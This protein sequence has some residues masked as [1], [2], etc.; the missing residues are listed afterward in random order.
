MELFLFQL[1]LAFCVL[2]LAA[3][4]VYLFDR[5]PFFE[6]AWVYLLGAGTLL[7]WVSFLVRIYNFWQAFP[8]SRFYL[9]INSYFAGLTMLALM[10]NALCLIFAWRYRIGV[11]GVFVLPVSL[12]TQ[13]NAW[14]WAD[15]AMT[16]LAADLRSVWMNLHPLILM[17]SYGALANSFGVAAA[18]LIQEGQIRSRKPKEFAWQIPA[19]EVL[20]RLNSHL[21]VMVLPVFTIG[22]IMGSFWAR[23]AWTGALWGWDAK[24]IGAAVT[25]AIYAILF[26]WRRFFRL[27]GRSAAYLQMFGFASVV[28]TFLGVNMFSRWHGYL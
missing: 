25:W 11:L 4:F 16:A 8:E 23:H 15:P 20:D 14:L 3:N 6:R 18:F 5:R 9:P 27:R 24:V 1:S 26:F 28:L 17:A 21:T 12:L 10:T 7:H 19:L 2:A 22:L 13:T